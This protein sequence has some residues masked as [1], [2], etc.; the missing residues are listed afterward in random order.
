LGKVPGVVGI[1]TGTTDFAGENLITERDTN[2]HQIIFVVLG[3]TDR[4]AD[5]HKLYD[6]VDKNYDWKEVKRETSF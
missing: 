6:W 2:G 4:Y 1:K 5:T 3:S